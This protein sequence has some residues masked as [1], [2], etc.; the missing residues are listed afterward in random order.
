[1]ILTSGNKGSII[2]EMNDALL[3]FVIDFIKKHPD[4][5]LQMPYI[6]MAIAAMRIDAL[7]EDDINIKNMSASKDLI[8]NAIEH[9]LNGLKGKSTLVRPMLLTTILRSIGYVGLR[10]KDMKVLTIGPRTESEIFL[11]IAAGFDPV[12]IKGMD[13]MSYS[14]L[15]DVGDMHD[16]SYEDDSFDVIIMGWVLA[17]SK[18]P[19]KAV[20]EARRVAKKDAVFAVGCEYSP[21]TFEELKETGSILSDDAGRYE[22]A[23]DIHDLF[24]GDVGTVWFQDDIHPDMKKSRGN[25]MTVF[26][27]NLNDAGK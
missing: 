10:M 7:K 27:R 6:C 2:P 16:M 17:Y 23:K 19:V 8:E 1:M 21:L 18:D 20:R 3:S 13:L 11:L 14:P 4:E 25:V 26:Q 15:I 12:N 22:K 24:E 5:V 9:N